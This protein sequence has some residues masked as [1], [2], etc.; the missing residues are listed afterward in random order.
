MG[1]NSSF[2]QSGSALPEPEGDGSGRR[3]QERL[4]VSPMAT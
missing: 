2:V 3:M 1:E 4:H